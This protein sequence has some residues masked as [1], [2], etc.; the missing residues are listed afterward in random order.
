MHL[1]AFYDRFQCR[2]WG[3]SGLIGLPKRVMNGDIG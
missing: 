2:R 1:L 3:A